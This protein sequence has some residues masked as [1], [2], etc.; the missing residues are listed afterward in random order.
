MNS[1]MPNHFETKSSV[2]NSNDAPNWFTQGLEK[3]I[4]SSFNIQNGCKKCLL[5]EV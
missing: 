3:V 2:F 5:F 1:N 4:N